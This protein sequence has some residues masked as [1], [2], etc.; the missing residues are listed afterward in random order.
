MTNKQFE[1]KRC[2]YCTSSKFN[3]LKHLDRLKTCD[4]LN[5]DQSVES[6]KDELI[7]KYPE[8]AP[9]CPHCKKQFENKSNVNRHMKT[10]SQRPTKLNNFGNETMDHISNNQFCQYVRNCYDGVRNCIRNIHFNK[11]FPQNWNMRVHGKNKKLLEV[12]EDGQWVECDKH[13]TFNTLIN[14]TVLKF[15]NIFLNNRDDPIFYQAHDYIDSFHSQMQGEKA[16]YCIHVHNLRR[17]IY[18]DLVRFTKEI[19]R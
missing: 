5:S 17:D 14:R 6:L 2:G 10:C 8:N 11:E 12:F 18:M 15:A 1:C 4:A 9:K 7:R 3:L 19:N 16:I 13:T